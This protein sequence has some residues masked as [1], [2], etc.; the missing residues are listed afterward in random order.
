MS[1]QSY[2]SVHSLKVVTIP[3]A[4]NDIPLYALRAH[5]GTYAP[6]VVAAGATS[7][8]VADGSRI[9]P[10][11]WLL[12]DS[13]TAGEV[14]Q[15][16]SVTG[17]VVSLLNSLKASMTNTHLAGA[18]VS[19]YRDA[20]ATISA[21]TT[22]YSKR[23]VGVGDSILR[24]AQRVTQRAFSAYD[25]T[26][27]FLYRACLSLGF[28]AVPLGVSGSTTGQFCQR[29][30]G[31]TVT[32]GLRYNGDGNLANGDLPR[33]CPTPADALVIE[34]G[35]ND[36]NQ[37]RSLADMVSNLQYLI[38]AGMDARFFKTY[39]Q[40]GRIYLMSVYS[41]LVYN[42]DQS[43]GGNSAGLHCN[44]AD[45]MSDLASYNKAIADAIAAS[46][47]NT[48]RPGYCQMVDYAHGMVLGTSLAIGSSMHDS[49]HPNEAGHAIKAANLAYFLANHAFVRRTG[50]S[51]L[52][53]TQI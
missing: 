8:T 44:L 15:V 38:A 39:A 42:T 26:N 10:G 23:I 48:G 33:Y 5:N 4:G 9:G 24:G 36:C 12:I 41:P 18:R 43:G 30:Y 45:Y 20:L 35:T 14:V 46:G 32:A 40:G 28:E 7:F 53:H 16:S 19:G 51:G 3:I 29:L 22:T 2:G 13:G 27:S 1:A 34:G 47:A 25:P 11:D 31:G 52:A 50:F 17:N 6:G 21:P 49:I 37:A